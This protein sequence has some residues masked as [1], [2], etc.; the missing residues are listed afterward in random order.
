MSYTPRFWTV[1]LLFSCM[2]GC[3][4]DTG[5]VRFAKVTGVVTYKG[6]P[7]SGAQVIAT[8]ASGPL[9]MASTGDDGKFS[10]RTNSREGV[11]VGKL[12]LAVVVAGETG[13]G[14]SVAPTASVSSSAD[15]GA[16]LQ[17]Q[18]QSMMKFAEQQKKDQASKKKK[19]D[20][21]PLAMYADVAT[22]NLSYDIKD[23]T[24]EPLK[25]ELK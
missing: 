13:P 4:E 7:V 24:N 23:G 14:E 12:R 15:P 11:A 8:P 10:L 25:V 22:S 21:S 9:A 5:G 6:A 19:V 3:G 18:M 1:V 2:L 16:A 20:K 17:G